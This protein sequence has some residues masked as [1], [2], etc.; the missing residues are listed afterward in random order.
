M[1]DA[2]LL[3][4]NAGLQ[5]YFQGQNQNATK[6]GNILNS[7]LLQGNK[8]V[9]GKVKQAAQPFGGLSDYLNQSTVAADQGVQNATQAAKDAATK[10]QDQF[11][12]GGGFI[13]NFE[14]DINS[15]WQA[16]L[17]QA[18]QR[19]AAA[20]A[21]LAG[22]TPDAQA[23]ADLGLSQ[24]EIQGLLGEQQEVKAGW[25][26]TIGQ[27]GNPIA[28]MP[29][30][31]KQWLTQ[32]SPDVAMQRGNFASADDYAKARAFQQLT[33]NQELS[34]FLPESSQP[35]TANPN[36]SQFNKQGAFDYL[37]PLYT[38]IEKAKMASN[39]T[40]NP[41]D[42]GIPVLPGTPAP[43][44]RSNP[45]GVESGGGQYTWI[46]PDGKQHGAF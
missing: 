25:S 12:Q 8:D 45:G 43:V 10:V 13:P 37:G 42:P 30:D 27:G 4:S 11:I 41:L 20:K 3:N 5:T 44:R 1:S 38:Q 32:Q 35:G 15:R 39:P 7:V 19:A 21:A 6:G 36:L 24:Q 17:G 31:L 18:N 40:T 23:L 2:A 33:G 28:G 29:I 46:G 9:Y 22:G 16:G 34:S 26:P 14:N